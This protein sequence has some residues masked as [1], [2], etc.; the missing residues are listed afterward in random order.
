M[1][2]KSQ[3]WR[4]QQGE[5]FTVDV[6]IFKNSKKEVQLITDYAFY[7]TLYDENRNVVLEKSTVAQDITIVDDETGRIQFKLACAET[8]D[9]PV[10]FYYHELWSTDTDTDNAMELKGEID[11]QEGHPP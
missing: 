10:G 5:D 3:N 4:M 9:L 1:A 11:L 6:H 7:W 8:E 2:I